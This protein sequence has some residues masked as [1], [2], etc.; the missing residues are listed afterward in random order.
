MKWFVTKSTG[1]V[2]QQNDGGKVLLCALT[3]T[4]TTFELEPG[5]T[6]AD[7][8]SWVDVHTDGQ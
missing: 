1:G 8:G 3:A 2:W 6:I 7:D 4:E 5:M